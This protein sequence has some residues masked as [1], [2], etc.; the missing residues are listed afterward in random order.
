M[1]TLI[2][3]QRKIPIDKD[4]VEALVKKILIQL[5]YDSFDIGILLTTNKTIATYNETYR[6]KKGPT[7]ILSFRYHDDIIPGK[8]IEPK[9]PEDQNLGD[10]ILSPEY[11]KA[12]ADKEGIPFKHRFMILLIHGICHLLGYDHE[13]EAEYRLMQDLENTIL[14]HLPRDLIS[15][16]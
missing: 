16:H 13:T 5:D 1:I 2:N 12:Y 11:I 6:G 3:R 8:R 9:T 14:N 15:Y 10:L 7:D 4:W